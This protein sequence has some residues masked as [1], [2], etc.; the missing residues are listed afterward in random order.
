M[1]DNEYALTH[2]KFELGIIVIIH[3]AFQGDYTTNQI[4]KKIVGKMGN[5][6]KII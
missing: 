4:F 1:A 5:S 2:S 3:N 6:M